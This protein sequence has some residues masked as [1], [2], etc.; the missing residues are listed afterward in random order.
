MIELTEDLFLGTGHQRV[1]YRHPE[2][3]ELCIK[4]L[5]PRR[6]ALRQQRQELTQLKKVSALSGGASYVADFH[7]VVNTNKGE[8][9][10]F[11][12]VKSDDGERALSLGEYLLSETCDFE[13]LSIELLKLRSFLLEHM[14]IFRDVNAT[15]ILCPMRSGLV[16]VVVIDGVGDRVDFPLNTLNLIPYFAR[17]KIKRRWLKFVKP[18]LR[19]Y[20]KLDRALGS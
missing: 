5:K 19:S 7:G 6:S 10:L 11:T 18:L 2:N 15:N 20:T 16:S 4:V 1:C 3:E 12:A 17:Q 13:R 9:Y 8:G 14:I